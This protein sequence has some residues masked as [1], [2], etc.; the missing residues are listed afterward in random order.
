MPYALLPSLLQCCLVLLSLSSACLIVLCLMQLSLSEDLS[1]CSLFYPVH[2]CTALCDSLSG[3]V[4]SGI[5]LSGFP[6]PLL[7]SCILGW[8]A[9]PV[10]GYPMIGTHPSMPIIRLIMI[11]YHCNCLDGQLNYQASA[12]WLIRGLLTSD[13]VIGNCSIAHQSLLSTVS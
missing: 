7:G 13:Y 5:A 10:I 1:F 3:L 4:H 8:P 12:H 9:W 2:I 6:G 11:G